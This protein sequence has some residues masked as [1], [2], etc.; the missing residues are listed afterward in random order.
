MIVSHGSQNLG[1]NTAARLAS[2]LSPLQIAAVL[3][4]WLRF[5]RGPATEQ[6]LMVASTAAVC[7]FIVF[8]RVLSP[9][10]LIWLAPLVVALPGRRGLAATGLLALAM[11]L[12][13]IWIPE[14]FWQLTRFEPVP[15][16]AVLGRDLV[17]LALLATLTWPDRQMRGSLPVGWRPRETT[18]T[19]A[20]CDWH[21]KGEERGSARS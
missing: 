12:T 3:L 19:A 5:M 9:Q 14:L 6:R 7:A 21:G 2:T 10:Y 8:G 1:G 18:S 15:S 16:W 11:G 4:V 17:L 13:Q 20:A